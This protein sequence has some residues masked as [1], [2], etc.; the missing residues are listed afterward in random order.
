L[1]P[2]HI[3]GK[4]MEAEYIHGTNNEEQRRLSMLNEIT[5]DSF[6][7]FLELEGEETI[8]DIGS[9]MGNLANNIVEKYPKTH[10]TGIELS[11][12]QLKKSPKKCNLSFVQGDASQLPFEN[13]SFDIVYTR[14]LLEHVK[15][16]LTVLNE[17]YR[18]LKNGGQLYI[19]ENNILCMQFYPECQLFMT[20][21][22][23]FANLQKS[24]GGDACIGKKL[25]SFINDTPFK[26]VQLFIEPEVHFYGKETFYYWIENLIEN[27]QGAKKLL[28]TNNFCEEEEIQ[29]AIKELISFRNNKCAAT[30]FYWNR[31]KARK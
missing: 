9:G 27:I 11:C 29:N 25:F 8:L 14:Y 31:L 28:I 20:V 13:N 10:I 4:I 19:Q 26:D 18:V 24:L 6:I 15:F 7:R 23:K 30:Y 16:P 3:R 12:E 21:W 22:E 1:R 5:N 17:A 2:T